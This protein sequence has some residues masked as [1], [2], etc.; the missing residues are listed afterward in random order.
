MSTS[1][2]QRNGGPRQDE[3]DIAN[4][5]P[6]YIVYKIGIYGWRK[7]C[8]YF[9]ILLILIIAIIN[10]ALT[11]WIIRVQD[12]SLKGMGKVHITRNG[13]RMDGRADFMDAVKAKHIFTRPDFGMKVKSY[14]N[15]SLTALDK[16]NNV[17]GQITLSRDRVIMKNKQLHIMDA[18]GK[19]LLYADKNKLSLNMDNMDIKVPG[20]LRFDN[21]IQTS[22][23]Q[24]GEFE[25]LKLESLTKQLYVSA[26][27]SIN[28]KSH[29]N[30][31]KF[32]SL[33]DTTLES[34]SGQIA[35]NSNKVK[36]TGL[37]KSSVSGNILNY[38]DAKE[39]CMCKDGTLFLAPANKN[40]P[41]TVTAGVCPS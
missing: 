22:L 23:V 8:L 10:L 6:A 41:C 17:M 26:G 38:P 24:A 39:V 33:K 13:I 2:R 21:S 30:D 4:H 11:I 34:T 9:L 20:G 36:M 32:S 29:G 15:V 25:N 27:E 7:R 14:H 18:S 16:N 1:P 37:R 40:S 35:L 12:F 28:L 3:I 19:T 5:D 31:I